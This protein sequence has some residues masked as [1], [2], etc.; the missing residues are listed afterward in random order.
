MPASLTHTSYKEQ[1]LAGLGRL[2]PF[3]PT[4]NRVLATLG[5]EDVSFS[6]LSELI[7]KDTVLG[8]N[9]LKLV[10]SAL[11]NRRAEISSIRYAVTLLGVNKLRN[12]VLSMSV[13][14]M[15]TGMKTPPGWSTKQFN[16]HSVAVAVLCDLMVQRI[17]VTY[18]EGA[19]AAGLLHDLGRLLI[20]TTL[21]D[22]YTRIME[23]YGETG[24]V[25]CE[26]EQHV[27]GIDH[28]EVSALAL[29][30]WNLPRPI[31]TAVRFHHAPDEDTTQVENGETRLSA[32]M[33]AANQY[34][35]HLGISVSPKSQ[36]RDAPL[37]N[38]FLAMMGDSAA[39]VHTA[40]EQ[41]FEAIRAFF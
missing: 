4:L 6:Y 40:F 32:A 24:Q 34:I 23:M 33:A 18:Q 17:P 15:W 10:N 29:V 41:E 35:N 36:E 5:R 11:Y 16:M 26:C 3:S 2:P 22:E 31:R 21:P 12:A 25:L 7:E 39:P 14:R 9:I 38:A 30:S 8:G 28:A 20:A 27:I 13:A 19:F 1:L 37:P